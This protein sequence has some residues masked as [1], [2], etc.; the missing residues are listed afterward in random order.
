MGKFIL[1]TILMKT[2]I[3]TL[4]LCAI[5]MT[6]HYE[7]PFSNGGTDPSC[8]DDELPAALPGANGVGCFPK[9]DNM[10]CPTDAADGAT[11]KPMPMIP[12]GEGNMYCVLICKGA[13]EGTCPSGAECMVPGPATGSV[14]QDDVGFCLFRPPSLSILDN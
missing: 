10:V 4:A 6:S 12:D 3:L 7:N 8:Y 11:A 14:S 2:T 13:Y 5:V 9:A 1:T